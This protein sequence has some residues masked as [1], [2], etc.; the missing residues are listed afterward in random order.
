LAEDGNYI[1]IDWSRGG[2]QGRD[3]YFT[4]GIGGVGGIPVAWETVATGDPR[5]P[6][7]T[8]IIIEIYQDEGPF[9]VNDTGGGVGENHIDVFVGAIPIA[10]ADELGTRSSRV[11]IVGQ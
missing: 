3:T 1:T 11:G 2:P 10:E 5:L 9:Q 7:G 6:F 4:Y 8:S